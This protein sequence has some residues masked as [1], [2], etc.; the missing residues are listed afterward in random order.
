M[1]CRSHGKGDAVL[2]IHGMPTNG[3]LWDNVVQELRCQYQCFV[4]ELPGMGGTPFVPYGPSYFAQMADQIE[5]VRIRNNVQRWHVVGHDGGAAIA[6]QYAHLFQERVSCLALLSPAIFADLRPPFPLSLLRMP[7][8]GEICAPFVHVLFWHVM[9]RCALAKGAGKSQRISFRKEFSG[10]AG[11]WRL[12]RLVRWGEPEN[13]F[14]DFPAILQGLRCPALLIH[15]S[16]DVLPES[17]ANRAAQMI[18]HSQLIEVEAGHFI[19]IERANYVSGKLNE[20]F[21][22]YLP[23]D[24]K[25]GDLRPQISGLVK[26]PDLSVPYPAAGSVAVRGCPVM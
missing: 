13:V 17:F 20:H 5:Q 3:R 15:G 14:K 21:R 11:P 19:P 1:R 10:L 23:E 8:I 9:M 2:F 26:R 6:V 24:E 25:N 16:H 12:M 4:I 18:P 22:S 7:F